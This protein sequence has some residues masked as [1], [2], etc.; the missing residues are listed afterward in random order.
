M[1]RTKRV[2]AR[3]NATLHP[4]VARAF[5]RIARGRRQN[6]VVSALVVSYAL[7]DA[8]TRTLVVE[9][10]KYCPVETGADRKGRLRRLADKL[11]GRCPR[12]WRRKV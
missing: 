10:G 7:S 4:A 2:I 11:A 1:S 8:D 5:R 3:L 9:A 12:V 6:D